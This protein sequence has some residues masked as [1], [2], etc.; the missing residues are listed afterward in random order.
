MY[1]LLIGTPQKPRPVTPTNIIKY[2]IQ[3]VPNNRELMD[4]NSKWRYDIDPVEDVF[5]GWRK[6]KQ[7]I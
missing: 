6:Y 4:K 7:E 3:Q 2:L 5:L 1:F